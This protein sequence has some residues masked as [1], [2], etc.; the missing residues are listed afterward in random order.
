MVELL[1]QVLGLVERAEEYLYSSLRAHLG[2][3]GNS[4]VDTVR[5]SEWLPE[6]W[7][8]G[9]EVREVWREYVGVAQAEADKE[10]ARRRTWWAP[11]ML[12]SGKARSERRAVRPAGSTGRV[13][14]F[15]KAG[16]PGGLLAGG[17]G[18][19]S[20]C[21]VGLL[22]DLRWWWET[23]KLVLAERARRVAGAGM[24]VMGG[25]EL[26]VGGMPS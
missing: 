20:Y 18:A 3:V 17:L 10:D 7:E 2:F 22:E 8:R 1:P 12:P 6:G 15:W 19:E 14:Q 21:R 16:V 24:A 11:G 23:V 5:F 26:G 25:G 9:R 13:R 4:F